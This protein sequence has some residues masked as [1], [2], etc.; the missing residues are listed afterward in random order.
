MTFDNVVFAGGGSRCTWQ[1]GFWEGAR[2]AGL[3]LN[4][5][6][7]YITSTSAGCAMAA[8]C[9]L[10]KGADSLRKFLVMATENERNIHWHNLKP[11]RDKPLL[12]HMKMYRRV[13][14]ET[15]EQADLDKLSHI[16]IEFLMAKYP[17]WLP[18]AL[19]AVL[20]FSVYGIE[21]HITG[22]LH[23]RWSRR[24]GF[25][26]LVAGNHDVDSIEEFINIILASSTVPPVLPSDGFRG[27]RVLDGGVIDNVPAFLTDD[28]P[29]NTLI[30]L[31]KQYSQAPPES[32]KRTY[33][34]PSK[35]ISLDKFDYANPEGLQEVYDLGVS[36][37]RA[38]AQSLQ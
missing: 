6:V 22:R 29:G 19:G 26:P 14:E 30:L 2:Q 16:K 27:Q 31:T 7:S 8:V 28:K 35:P 13:L 24:L 21:K 20:A 9:L 36:D 11:T 1:I 17:K 34:Q 32:D 5:Q 38:F 4:A 15:L 18:S 23:P 3:D 25:K 12:P 33:V 10:D 37:G